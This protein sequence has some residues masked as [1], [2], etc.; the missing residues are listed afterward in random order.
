MVYAP[1]R[2]KS[3]SGGACLLLHAQTSG[4]FN[5]FCVE[6]FEHIIHL[7]LV[8][9]CL[10]L[11]YHLLLAYHTIMQWLFAVY[12]RWVAGWHR[13]FTLLLHLRASHGWHQETSGSLRVLIVVQCTGP[14]SSRPR[15]QLGLSVP[16]ACPPVVQNL[17]KQLVLFRADRK[18]ER[19]PL[20]LISYYDWWLIQGSYEVRLIHISVTDGDQ[21]SH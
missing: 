12:V 11:T 19:P 21:P 18:K 1:L 14:T 8:H 17:R 3:S 15:A 9:Y 2:W 13:R 16:I 6:K 10:F 7:L 4:A 20:P 5:S